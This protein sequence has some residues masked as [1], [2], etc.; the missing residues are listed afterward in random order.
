LPLRIER[1]HYRADNRVM[2]RRID[3]I[4]L[5]VPSLPPAV[6]YYRDALG[7]KLL[8]EDGRLALLRFQED[9]AELVLHTDPDLPADAVYYLVDDVRALFQKRDELKLHFTHPPGPGARGW[10]AAIKDPFGNVMLIVDRTGDKGAS[11]NLIEDAKPPGSLFGGVEAKV[12]VKRDALVRAYQEIGRTADDLPYTPDFEKLHVVYSAQH[13]QSK[14]SKQETWRHLLNLRKAGKL[15]KLGEAR[16]RP[17]TVEESDRERL[18]AMLG[19]DIGRRDRLPYTERF[20]QLVDEFN[21]TQHRPLSPHLVW[22][23]VA[24]LAK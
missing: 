15:P 9:E 5:R 11:G 24:T 3:R 10:R 12:E 8:K 2:L 17:P 23:L 14:P 18:R 19:S 7:L 4:I 20:D 21:Q 16:S 1:G 6:R 13:K 22:R